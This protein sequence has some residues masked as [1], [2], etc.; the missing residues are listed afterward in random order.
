MHGAGVFFWIGLSP[1]LGRCL[2]TIFPLTFNPSL[3]D[4]VGQAARFVFS[5][6]QRLLPP[7]HG[8]KQESMTFSKDLHY[9]GS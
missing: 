3:G 9:F 5:V 1:S 7:R 4:V 8:R 2:V 6:K